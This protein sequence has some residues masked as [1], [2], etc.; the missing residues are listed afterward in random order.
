MLTKIQ[1]LHF[2]SEKSFRDWFFK[3]RFSDL[4]K[5]FLIIL[6][7]LKTLE[8]VFYHYVDKNSTLFFIQGVPK[9]IICWQKLN[10]CI[11]TQKWVFMMNFEGT[12][13]PSSLILC[14]AFGCP[15]SVI[16]DSHFIWIKIIATRS[17]FSLLTFIY[18]IYSVY[19][20]L[21]MV[22][23]NQHILLHII[24]MRIVYFCQQEYE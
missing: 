8:L 2:G 1:N 20:H 5:S 19:W 17:H 16:C 13:L 22:L 11:L 10:N 14:N 23:K 6:Y 15:E 21:F 12:V 4:T 7:I 9:N 3:E 18:G 24:I